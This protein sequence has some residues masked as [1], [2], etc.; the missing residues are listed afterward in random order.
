M[1]FLKRQHYILDRIVENAGGRIVRKVEEKYKELDRNLCRLI[2]D[3]MNS[4]RFPENAEEKLYDFSGESDSKLVLIKNVKE[5]YAITKNGVKKF[6]E[7]RMEGD[8]FE[9]LKL[10]T[11]TPDELILNDDTDPNLFD[12]ICDHIQVV[13]DKYKIKVD[14]KKYLIN[15]T[16]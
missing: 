4:Q 11:I 12:N 8:R 16:S 3:V 6:W 15:L 5:T 14:P 13:I 9:K 2:Y 1:S 7:L 10:T